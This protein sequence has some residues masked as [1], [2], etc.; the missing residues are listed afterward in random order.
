MVNLVFLI[1]P[2]I[3]L[4]KN[5][6]EYPMWV[7]S[8]TGE[9]TFNNVMKTKNDVH[10]DNGLHLGHQKIN[11]T[12]V[13]QITTIVEHEIASTFNCT[14]CS[15]SRSPWPC[16]EYAC[17]KVGEN[18]DCRL[19]SAVKDVLCTPN[20][21]NVSGTC[22]GDADAVCR[23][24]GAYSVTMS[25]NTACAALSSGQV[26]CWGNMPYG[27]GGFGDRI[28]S[29]ISHPKAMRQNDVPHEIYQDAKTVHTG[30]SYTTCV[31]M[32]NG[33][34]FCVGS[35][36]GG[37]LGIGSY[38]PYQVH[39]PVQ[40]HGVNNVDYLTSVQKLV[41]AA[42]LTGGPVAHA[43]M[44]NGNVLAWGANQEFA[45]GTNDTSVPASLYPVRVHGINNVGTLDCAIDVGPTIAL[46]CDNR[47][48]TWGKTDQ[49]G[50]CRYPC[51]VTFDSESIKHVYAREGPKYALMT[52]SGDIYTWGRFV[53]PGNGSSV[54]TSITSLYTPTRV[55]IPLPAV[56]FAP[57]DYGGVILLNN[58]CVYA[59]RPG[60]QYGFGDRDPD[61]SIPEPISGIANNGYLCDIARLGDTGNIVIDTHGRVI[62]WGRNNVGQLG[63]GTTKDRDVPVYVLLNTYKN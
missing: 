59:W 23:M 17:V 48:I 34:V 25:Y 13:E 50:T 18:F 14:Q 44:A 22:S 46:T 58:T 15:E 28:L 7:N 30:G 24:N 20:G 9:I 19:V 10:M 27:N 39:Y 29:F 52:T 41:M 12:T 53:C 51:V 6:S 60:A 36:T 61:G 49:Y 4:A 43:L 21:A 35:N 55:K 26:Y 63:D 1:L 11:E 2:V 31:L 33:T 57:L 38:L 56:D 47:L 5:A 16:Q 37:V 54:Q 42:V 45:L 3:V 40:V 32:K 62:T 8:D